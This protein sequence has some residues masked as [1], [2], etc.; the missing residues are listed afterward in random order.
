MKKAFQLIELLAVII[1][2]AVIA[3][4]ATPIVLNVVDNAKESARKSSV[5][6]YADAV[7]LARTEAQF[8]NLPFND[9]DLSDL[10]IETSTNN[11]T[12]EV[13]KFTNTAGIILNNC[14]VQEETNYCYKMGTVEKGDNCATLLSD[15]PQ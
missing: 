9:N 10:S 13:V 2:L 12:C 4:I 15:V 11:V 1:I 5:A 6:G 3:L 8:N 14:T 7:K